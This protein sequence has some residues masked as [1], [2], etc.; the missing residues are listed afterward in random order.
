MANGTYF[1]SSVEFSVLK[2]E[3]AV[4][5]S[6][7]DKRLKEAGLL[8]SI[9]SESTNTISESTTPFGSTEDI[10]HN[11]D[12]PGYAR[13]SILPT[14]PVVAKKVKV[15]PRQQVAEEV[16]LDDDY[17]NPADALKINPCVQH[18]NQQFSSSPSPPSSPLSLLGRSSPYESVDEIRKM[19]EKQIKE[20]EKE[21]RRDKQQQGD[22]SSSHAGEATGSNDKAPVINS[23]QYDDNPGYST[24]FDALRGHKVRDA[25]SKKTPTS[26]PWQRTSSNGKE[27]SAK[28]LH[29]VDASSPSGEDLQENP[30]NDVAPMRSASTSLRGTKLKLA[31]G[32]K[33]SQTDI[34]SP[35]GP[36]PGNQTSLGGSSKQPKKYILEVANGKSEE[37]HSLRGEIGRTHSID[38]T[39]RTPAVVTKL[40]TGHGTVVPSKLT[41]PP[42]AKPLRN[43]DKKY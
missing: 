27:P 26:L 43:N 8:K 14:G 41:G 20:R 6:R 4:M 1:L 33:R 35:I 9:S 10:M 25:A 24:P 32:G 11:V 21:E 5:S 13:L 23:Y 37:G 40:R 39:L 7:F 22:A 3:D 34:P 18:I 16:T 17:A 19:R 36:K 2:A 29:L 38:S 30:S 42:K 15:K 28:F 31:G 12:D